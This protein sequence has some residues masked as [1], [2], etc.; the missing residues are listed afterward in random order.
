ME[1]RKED[2][3]LVRGEHRYLKQN[4]RCRGR[5]WLFI[6][7]FDRVMLHYADAVIY[8]P[9][10]MAEPCAR[11]LRHCWIFPLPWYSHIMIIPC[12]WRQFTIWERVIDGVCGYSG[13]HDEKFVIWPWWHLS[14]VRTAGIFHEEVLLTLLAGTSSYL[15]SRKNTDR[16]HVRLDHQVKAFGDGNGS[17]IFFS[18]KTFVVE[19]RW[20]TMVFTFSIFTSLNR[21]SFMMRRR[22]NTVIVVPRWWYGQ[23]LWCMNHDNL[24]VHLV[25]F[26][27]GVDKLDLYTRLVRVEEP[28]LMIDLPTDR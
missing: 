8:F 4:I 26:S 22:R 18:E 5:P 6:F 10:S 23:T 1:I 12:A 25:F 28:Q 16:L 17:K 7:C 11:A 27:F 20:T 24:F 15:R 13:N 9:E 3:S 14:L 19:W 2:A 21:P